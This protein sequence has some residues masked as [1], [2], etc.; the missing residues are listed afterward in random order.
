MVYLNQLLTRRKKLFTIMFAS[1][2]AICISLSIDYYIYEE[3]ESGSTADIP[4][5]TTLLITFG[6]ILQYNLVNAFIYYIMY[7]SYR[8]AYEGSHGLEIPSSDTELYNISY[9]GSK[10]QLPQIEMNQ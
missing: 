5:L 7:W 10:E 1:L 2:F 9:L 6:K 4:T 8:Y 3:L